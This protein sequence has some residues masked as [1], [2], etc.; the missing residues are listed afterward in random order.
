MQELDGAMEVTRGASEDQ[1]NA[2]GEGPA[3]PGVA[4]S[5]VHKQQ[6]SSKNTKQ[7]QNAAE[8]SPTKEGKL[9][10]QLSPDRISEEVALF[11]SHVP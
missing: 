10:P 5:V 8:V 11:L 4:A 2:A 7:M 1:P 9:A 6:S 3:E